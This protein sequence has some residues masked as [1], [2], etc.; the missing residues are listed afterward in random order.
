[1]ADQAVR[2][3]KEEKQ[4]EEHLELPADHQVCLFIFLR[5][6]SIP[7]SVSEDSSVT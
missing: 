1:M 5:K 6:D 2:V 7:S 4:S 3:R